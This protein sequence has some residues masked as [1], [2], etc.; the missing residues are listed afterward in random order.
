VL[1]TFATCGSIGLLLGFW[2]RVPALVAA[3][4]VIVVL[5]SSVHRS[6]ASVRSGDSFC[7]G[8]RAS[9]RIPRR[10]HAV[11]RL[12]K[13]ALVRSARSCVWHRWVVSTEQSPNLRY[14]PR[15]A[16]WLPKRHVYNGCDVPEWRRTRTQARS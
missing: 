8:G 1:L 7:P 9:G 4:S 16:Y 11:L 2:F 12:V 6:R 3:S 13:L 15:R 14:E 5:C 10:P